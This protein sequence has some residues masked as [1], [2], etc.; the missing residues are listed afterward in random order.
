MYEL[1]I[2][3][4]GPSGMTAA[5][6]AARKKINTLL[7]AK[8]I[9]GQVVTT[10]GIENYMGYQYVEGFDLM[11]KFEQ[12]LKQFPIGRQDGEEVAVVTHLDGAFDVKSASGE[13]F[14]AKAVIIATGKKPRRL[15]VPGEKELTGRGVSYCCVCDG[16]LFAGEDVAVIGGGN[17]ALEA[18]DDLLKIATRVYSIADLGFTGDAVLVERVTSNPKLTLYHGYQVVEISGTERVEGIVIRDTRTG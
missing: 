14:Q 18:I 9:G 15:D 7:L 6:Y 5:V 10:R 2:V 3:G 16:P 17:S 12:Q 13:E 11:D 4:A 8:E 1:I